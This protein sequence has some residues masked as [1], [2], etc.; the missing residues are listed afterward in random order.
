MLQLDRH[1]EKTEKSD[2]QSTASSKASP[3]KEAGGDKTH[4]RGKGRASPA[5]TSASE[6]MTKLCVIESGAWPRSVDIRSKT[7][8]ARSHRFVFPRQLIAMLM[9]MVLRKLDKGN[10][11]RRGRVGRGLAGWGA[12]SGPLSRPEKRL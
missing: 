10:A 6:L 4:A 1:N 12:R 7:F 5:R 2:E 9:R 8:T 11:S 3:D